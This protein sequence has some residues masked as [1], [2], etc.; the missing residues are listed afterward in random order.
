[1]DYDDVVNDLELALKETEPFPRNACRLARRMLRRQDKDPSEIQRLF[2]VIRGIS[3]HYGGPEEGGWWFDRE[4]TEAVH[5]AFGWRQ[6]RKLIRKLEKE[7]QQPRFGINSCANRGEAE[8]QF[9]VIDDLDQIPEDTG[10]SK[11]RYE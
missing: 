6:T 4:I 9:L 7:Y 2:V 5:Q 10:L 3:R 8:Y 1:M 11:P